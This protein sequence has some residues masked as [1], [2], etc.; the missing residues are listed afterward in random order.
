MC[1]A[2]NPAAL[3]DDSVYDSGRRVGQWLCYDFEAT[4]Y[5]IRSARYYN[6]KTWVVERSTDS[7]FWVD[8]DRQH[9]NHDFDSDE[10]VVRT[11]PVSKSVEVRR[12]LDKNQA[13]NFRPVLCG[14]EVFGTLGGLLKCAA[15]NS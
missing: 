13:R 3:G 12:Q 2:R 11:F 8:L 1:A 4:H 10:K 9:E 7:R 15:A 14:F 6:P 5:T